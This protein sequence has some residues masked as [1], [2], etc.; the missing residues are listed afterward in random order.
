M[1]SY[2]AETQLVD[3][4]K[5]KQYGDYFDKSFVLHLSILFIDLIFALLLLIST[6]GVTRMNL[7]LVDIVKHLFRV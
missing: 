7:L 5:G 6:E 4:D 2:E 1:V 3:A